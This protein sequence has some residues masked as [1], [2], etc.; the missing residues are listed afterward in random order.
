[1]APARFAAAAVR[2]TTAA[3]AVMLVRLRHSRRGD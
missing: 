3:T 2:A 1:M